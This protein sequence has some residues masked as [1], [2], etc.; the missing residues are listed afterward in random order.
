MEDKKMFNITINGK[1]I[2][3]EAGK[4]ILQVAT[5]N[6]IDIPNLCYS[7]MVKVYGSCGVC[8]VEVEGAPKL[9]RACATK[10]SDG[11]V[12]NTET[13]RVKRARKTALSLMLSDHSGDCRPPCVRECPAG[14]DCQGYVGLIAN[15][16][17]EEAN[18][19]I[20]EKLP[21]PASIG[22]VCPHPC[23]TACRRKALEEPVSIM[24]L[25]RFAAD[26][27]IAN[28]GGKA[29]APA[30]AAETGKKVAII[31]GG[32]AGLSAAYFLRA[33][34]H[35]VTIYDKMPKM[36]GMLRYG[37]PEY[38]LPK[39]VLDI[40]IEAIEGMGV[41]MVNNVLTDAEM[42]EKLR[43]END[44]V[45]IAIG[46]WT[47][48]KMRIPGEDL[49]GV[50]GGID[51]LRSIALG[52]TLPLGKRVAVVG[53]GNT[54]MDACRSAVRVG[55]D[56][57]YVIYRR[58]RDEM[59]AEK[60]EIEEAEEE[61]VIYKFLCNPVEILGADG[62]VTAIKA[63]KMELGEPDASGRCKPVPVEG[64]FEE[65][66]VDNVIMA[67]GQSINNKGFES[68][69]LTKK[70]TIV[71]DEKLFTT[72]LDGVFACGDVTNRGAGIAIAAIGEAKK[73]AA[74]MHL[75]L[76]GAKPA[77]EDTAEY[78][79]YSI[80][81]PTDEQIREANAHR[82]IEARL[83]PAQRSAEERKTNFK[84]YVDIFDAEAAK[85][86]AERCLECGCRD[87]FEC[88]L[89]KYADRY[90]ADYERVA[91][92]KHQRPVVKTKYIVREPEKCILCGLCVRTCEEVMGITALGLVGRGF[93]TV[94][95]PEMGLALE[96][97]KCNNCGLC[98]S[99][100][101]T[102]ALSEQLPLAKAVPL[103]ETV[104]EGICGLCDKACEVKV[105][106]HGNTPLRVLPKEGGKLLCAEGR[107][108]LVDGKDPLKK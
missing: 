43:N 92:S 51:F 33:K 105:T 37:I 87:Y 4:S 84:E 13:D 66:A 79:I 91:G 47:S 70:G 61:G 96:S 78:N 11:M 102:G 95:L 10:I 52:E 46:A 2:E 94:V 68:V 49:E 29:Y 83:A 14:T 106:Y 97:T 62:K 8:V 36:G 50:Y 12:V 65:I 28:N 73:A 103:K 69:E 16:L 57:V 76:G 42:F 64:A 89:I 100:C 44:A 63:Q 53:G 31:G 108:A 40:E 75:Y 39:A 54:A 27:S 19:L 45:L 58:T 15:G 82:P 38:R 22:R 90:D 93:D 99:V 81:N 107:F 71:A 6:G 21:L 77:F 5:E 18:E 48:S 25:K 30:V 1:Q 41:K 74:A 23:E 88:K 56:E 98:V 80:K 34:G 35:D 85:K 60:V 24:Q 26:T 104:K 9:F 86:E 17:F 55:A 59:P 3:A 101:P 20:K 72:S 32:P 67:I 7:D